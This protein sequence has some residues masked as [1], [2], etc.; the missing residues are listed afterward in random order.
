MTGGG[1]SGGE[2][3]GGGAS[4]GATVMTSVVVATGTSSSPSADATASASTAPS[5][6]DSSLAAASKTLV[7]SVASTWTV[8]SRTT[9]KVAVG[10]A[11]ST[12]VVMFSA[13]ARSC[14]SAAEK[15]VEERLAVTLSAT[16]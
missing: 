1:G 6:A 13:V 4:G 2:G 15:A 14:T 11:T 5:D 9:P 10:A 16:L 12:V 8:L 3:G 7:P